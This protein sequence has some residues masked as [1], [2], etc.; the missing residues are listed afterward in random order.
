LSIS[1]GALRI[2]HADDRVVALCA[3]ARAF[4]GIA[5]GETDGDHAEQK[6]GKMTHED[7]P[8]YMIGSHASE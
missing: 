8:E 5:A 2:G 1:S 7:L 4:P 6:T 3:I